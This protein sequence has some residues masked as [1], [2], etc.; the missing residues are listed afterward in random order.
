MLLGG[1]KC[2]EKIQGLKTGTTS[3]A[4]RSCLLKKIASF[5]P[6]KHRDKLSVS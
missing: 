4:S 6:D 1:T 5:C 3:E 2:H